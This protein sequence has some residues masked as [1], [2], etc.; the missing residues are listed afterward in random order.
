MK[1]SLDPQTIDPIRSYISKRANEIN[2]SDRELM[3]RMYNYL[4][5]VCLEKRRDRAPFRRN[6]PSIQMEQPGTHHVSLKPSIN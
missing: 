4:V 3:E 2:I 1:S 5:D 6:Y